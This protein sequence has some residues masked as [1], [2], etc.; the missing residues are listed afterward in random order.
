L[1]P[2]Y[3]V[4]A[5]LILSHMPY[6]GVRLTASLYALHLQASPLVVGLLLSLFSFIPML[7]LVPLGRFVDRQGMRVPFF[8]GTLGLLLCTLLA[9]LWGSLVSLFVVAALAGASYFSIFISGQQLVGRYSTKATRTQNFV[10]VGICFSVSSVIAP[11]TS[12]FLI[13]HI[14]FNYTFLALTA[15][16]IAAAAIVFANRL[17][18]IGPS[19]AVSAPAEAASGKPAPKAGVMGLVRD[20]P[21]RRLYVYGI[22]FTV[23][24]DVFLFLTPIYGTELKLSASQIGVI[25]GSFSVGTFCVRMFSMRLTRSFTN[26]QLLLIALIGMATGCLAYG[27][28][29]TTVLM[30]SCALVMGFGHGLANP[31]LNSLLYET[32]PPD[33]VAEAMGLRMSIGKVFQIVLPTVSGAVSSLFGVAPMFWAVA[34]VQF[35]TVYLTRRQWRAPGSRS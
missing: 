16:P 28:A 5:I 17:P 2:L 4:I 19:Q 7:G 23:S 22:M 14:G 9:G 1:K 12:G 8:A 32:S 33:R 15:M 26:W 25:L 13:D 18:D 11:V 21:L 34:A 29:G 10:L 27:F 35:T 20:R 6:V 30:M 31:I 24:W 3:L